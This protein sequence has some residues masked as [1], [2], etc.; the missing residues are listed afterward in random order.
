MTAQERFCLIKDGIEE[1]FSLCNLCNES[2][3][4]DSTKK[5]KILKPY[6]LSGLL[7]HLGITK[8]EFEKLKC[9]NK[10]KKLFES[11]LLRIEAF[12]EENAL[13]G[14]LSA[15]AASNSLKYHF[16]WGKETKDLQPALP[17]TLKIVLDSDVIRF[18]E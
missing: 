14:E 5:H 1:Y 13:T 18:A 10:Y 4:D 12:T 9:K 17:G 2:S 15:S 7:F 6:S 16:G 11:A 8:Y 3:K